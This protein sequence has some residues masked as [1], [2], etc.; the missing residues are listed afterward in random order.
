M[1]ARSY[2]HPPVSKH[3]GPDNQDPETSLG[4]AS[5][6]E[7]L[8]HLFGGTIHARRGSVVHQTAWQCRCVSLTGYTFDHAR[9]PHRCSAHRGCGAAALALVG[10]GAGQ[11]TQTDSQFSAV[12][13]A[14]GNV[15]NSIAL[16]N[17]LIPYPHNQ[18]HTYPIGSSVPVLLN[19]TNQGNSADE[20]VGVDSPVASQ[21]LVEGTEQLPRARPSPALPVRIPSVSGPAARWLSGSCASC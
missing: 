12:D 18:A 20:L 13:G 7:G 16:R 15:G 3:G 5:N 9:L 10:C 4:R 19:I 8:A 17:V 2:P 14:F 21:A 6:G 11:V 1:V